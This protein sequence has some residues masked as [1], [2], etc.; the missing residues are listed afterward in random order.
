[1]FIF[2]ELSAIAKTLTVKLVNTLIL[3]GIIA[4]ALATLALRNVGVIF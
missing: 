3:T 1:M 2:I 4:R